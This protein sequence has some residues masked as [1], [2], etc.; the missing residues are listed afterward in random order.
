MKAFTLLL[1]HF[2]AVYSLYATRQL[3]DVI[4]YKGKERGLLSNPLEQYLE[5]SNS[6]PD[7]HVIFPD[8]QSTACWRGYI[9][10]WEIDDDILYLTKIRNCH[11]KK[12]V[13][14]SQIVKKEQNN[15]RRTYYHK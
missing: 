2:L 8:G 10:Y 5:W 9:A 6:W 3:G 4:A 13:A 15:S 11:S 1:I 7:F 14:L 12:E